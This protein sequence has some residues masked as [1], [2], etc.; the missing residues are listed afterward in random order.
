[1]RISTDWVKGLDPEAKDKRI[2]RL[3]ECSDVLELLVGFL[4]QEEKDLSNPVTDYGVAN[5][6]YLQADR[7]GQ[8][9]AIQRV[10]ARLAFLKED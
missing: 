6:A 7:L 5:W 10:K 3:L 4:E 2:K 9:K 1:M 8:L